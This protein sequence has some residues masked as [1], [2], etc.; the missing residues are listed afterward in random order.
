MC[1][2]VDQLIPDPEQ[3]AGAGPLCVAGAVEEDDIVA[4][5]GLADGLAVHP[6][7]L[8]GVAVVVAP[9]VH[10]GEQHGVVG[11]PLAEV[12][13]PPGGPFTDELPFDYFLDPGPRLRV[14]QIHEGRGEA[15]DR[16]LVGLASMILYQVAV[17]CGLLEEVTAMILLLR[18]VV[19]EVVTEERVYV[20]HEPDIPLFQALPQRTPIGVV[21]PVQFPVPPELGADSWSSAAPPSPVARGRLWAYR[22]IRAPLRSG[23]HGPYRP[24][25]QPPRR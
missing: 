20:A 23:A 21:I 18:G 1:V 15:G 14:R 10:A 17:P 6:G 9:G 22:V 19:T 16:D 2:P 3:G 12:S 13:H 25:V 4:P 11:E 8:L 5:A 7:T 24:A